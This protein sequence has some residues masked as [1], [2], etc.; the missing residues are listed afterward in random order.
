MNNTENGSDLRRRVLILIIHGCEMDNVY[1]LVKFEPCKLTK[2][3]VMI[4]WVYRQ[5]G[6]GIP[7]CVEQIEKNGKSAKAAARGT[8]KVIVLQN[9]LECSGFVAIS[10]YDTKPF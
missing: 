10:L 3:K 2:S 8:L 1:T 6:R 4:E 5:S 7:S 9:D